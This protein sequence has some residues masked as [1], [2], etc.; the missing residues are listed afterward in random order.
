MSDEIQTITD[1]DQIKGIFYQHFLKGDIY[2]KT[3]NGDLKIQFL[4]ISENK[5]AFKIPFI[6]NFSGIGL[7]LARRETSIIYVQLK[8]LERSE[9]DSFIFHPVKIQIINAQRREDRHTIGA[10]S[11]SKKVIY[12]TNIISDFIMENTL[13]MEN[14]KVER[15]KDILRSDIERHFSYIKIFFFNE[16]RSDPR[17][18][19]FFH[20]N[21]PIYIF[22]IRKKPTSDREMSEYNN[23]INEIYSKDYYL[24]NRKQ[25]ISEIAV[26]FLFRAKIPYG[27]IQVNSTSP[28]PENIMSII[29]KIAISC[30]EMFTKTKFFPVSEEKLLVS[31]ISRNGLSLAFRE[32]KFI[33]YFKERCLVYFDI[34]LPDKKKASI[35]AEVRN[36]VLLENKIIKVGCEIKEMD[37]ISEVNFEEFLESTIHKPESDVTE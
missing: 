31:D 27:Y 32:R 35:Q 29:K 11:Q 36:I 2:L 17:M 15:I 34:M 16:G 28:I 5:V 25:Y 4:G 14:K 33:R 6:K 9:D 20:G 21:R 3:K 24:Q 1:Q 23:Y 19:Y 18:R 7:V 30:D 8:F 22:D 26:P 10:D 13:S 37:A 12:V